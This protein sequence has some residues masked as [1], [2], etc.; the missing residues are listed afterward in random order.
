MNSTALSAIM[1]AGALVLPP[2]TV[3]I[4]EQSTIRKPWIP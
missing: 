3:G 1:T 4:T 2:G